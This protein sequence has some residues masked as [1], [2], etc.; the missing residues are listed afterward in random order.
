MK[1]VL[2]DSDNSICFDPKK[3][4]EDQLI[5]ISEEV[6]AARVEVLMENPVKNTIHLEKEF[7]SLQKSY[8]S[9]F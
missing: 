6:T 7:K 9:I 4:R 8:V 1:R 3:T 2:N 5:D